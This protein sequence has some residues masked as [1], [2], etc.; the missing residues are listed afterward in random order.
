MADHAPLAAAYTVH[1]AVRWEWFL[2]EAVV[3]HTLNGW[4]GSL[5]LAAGVVLELIADESTTSDV[6]AALMEDVGLDEATA[7]DSVSATVHE[8]CDRDVLVPKA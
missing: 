6:I 7:T 5:N 1:S 3:L 2:D 4:R 8:L